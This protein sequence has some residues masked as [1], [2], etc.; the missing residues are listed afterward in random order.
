MRFRIT[1]LVAAMSGFIALSY[2]ILWYRAF[3]FVSWSHPTAFGLLLGAYLFGVAIGAAFSRR[4][5][6]EAPG[7]EA[8]R[9]LAAF[10]FFADLVGFLVVPALSWL[11]TWNW[12]PGLGLVAVS[13]GLMGAVLPLVAHYGIE[14]DDR[15]GANLSYV[16][17]A[18]IIGS[19]SGSFFTG[20]VL[21]DVWSTRGISVFLALLG[22]A[23]V[24]FLLLASR[25]SPMQ[26]AAGL[27]AAAAFAAVCALGTSPLFEGLYE[28][29]L[30]KQKAASFP[31]LA[32]VLENRHGVIVVSQYARIYGGGAYDGAFNVSLVD[33][34]NVIERAFAVSALHPKPRDV[35]MIGLSSGSWAQ[36]VSHLPGVE[37][38]TII[39]INPGY[40]EL[41]KLYPAVKSLLENPKVD[42][43]IDDG[44]RWLSRHPERKFDFI[45][46]NTT[47]HW[48]AHSTN[49]LSEEYLRTVREHLNP[50]G[51][52]YFNT[53]SSPEAQR[54]AATVFPYA[55]RI[56][57]FI[58]ASDSP[59][60]FDRARW[61]RALETMVIDGV[62]ALDLGE[63]RQKELLDR[64][65][66]LPDTLDEPYDYWGLERRDGILA[67]TSGAR[68][69]TDDNMASETHP[70][71]ELLI[72]ED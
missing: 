7:P 72:Y 51:V 28:R 58:A 30:F 71:F 22:L 63:P 48:R 20:F 16:Y 59:L 31:P 21:M 68:I 34:K 66:A 52:H 41:I 42:F 33:D 15:A 3:S 18:N 65:L 12:L 40:L 44:R 29:L 70:L 17:L 6:R 62:P 25:P 50:G 56:I 19:A 10:I 57:N 39:E 49:L 55:M 24:A 35:L 69:I 61:K 26:R 37:H 13:A 32:H 9:P 27:G 11:A 38:L 23:M 67:R 5:C 54:T 2:E 64:L 43:V 14:P 36:V 45:V 60:D 8:L 53:T 46:M 4:F 47:Y 1:L